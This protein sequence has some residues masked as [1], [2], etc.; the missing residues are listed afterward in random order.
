MGQKNYTKVLWKKSCSTLLRLPDSF[1]YG[2]RA[3]ALS[4][5]CDSSINIWYFDF[6]SFQYIFDSLK[7]VQGF[8]RLNNYYFELYELLRINV[9]S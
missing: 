9:N 5:M 1:V 7:I 6:S 2:M 3:P 8:L 4:T